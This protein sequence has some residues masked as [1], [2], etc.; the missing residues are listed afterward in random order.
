MVDTSAAAVSKVGRLRQWMTG[1]L[2]ALCCC[3]LSQFQF[4]VCVSDSCICCQLASSVCVSLCHQSESAESVW[5]LRVE[6]VLKSKRGLVSILKSHKNL[7][8]RN[9]KYFDITT[10]QMT[11]EAVQGMSLRKV[12]LLGS[13]LASV[14]DLKKELK[15]HTVCAVISEAIKPYNSLVRRQSSSLSPNLSPCRYCHL[16]ISLKAVPESNRRF[17]GQNQLPSSWGCSP[18]PALLALVGQASTN[19]GRFQVCCSRCLQRQASLRKTCYHS[20]YTDS[21]Q[22]STRF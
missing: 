11:C 7:G 8:L 5:Q 17:R 4:C 15:I 18:G 13:N 21:V 1:V 3:C 16:A 12:T 19:T 2:T 6:S 9:N 22:D 10:A 14:T 20:C